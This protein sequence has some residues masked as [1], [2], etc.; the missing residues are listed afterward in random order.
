[1]DQTRKILQL[2][3]WSHIRKIRKMA[4]TTE[5]HC[6]ICRIKLNM[7]VPSRFYYKVY[8]EKRDFYEQFY[9]RLEEAKNF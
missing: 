8:E 1:M 9:E 3:D 5:F 4:H 6:R 2:S 7:H